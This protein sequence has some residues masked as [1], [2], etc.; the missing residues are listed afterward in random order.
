VLALLGRSIPIAVRMFLLTFAIVDDIAAILIIAVVY[1]GGLDY[2]GLLFVAA[3]FLVV[4]GFQAIGIGSAFA[5]LLPGAIL[6]FGLLDAG[7][8][9]TLA[10]VILGM[11]TPVRPMRWREVPLESAK[12]ALTD[13]GD[14]I[15]SGDSNKMLESVKTLET[16]QRDLLP[17]V[18]RVQAALHPWVAYGVMPLFA[19]ANAGVNLQ[20]LDLAGTS[21]PRLISAIGVALVIGKP[22]GILAGSWLAVRVGA[23]QLAPGLTWF[24]IL[25]AACLGGIGF[26]MSIFIASLAFPDEQMLAA[27]KLGVLVASLLA[28]IAG[29][30]V[31]RVYLR[32]SQATALPDRSGSLDPCDQTRT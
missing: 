15:R 14:R 6:W 28:G 20:G 31:G 11:M 16:A 13:L 10:G 3:G 19:L 8:H 27:A 1:S 5:Y 4:L 9:P 23:C 25:L 2:A 7:L 30:A 32:R 12:R 29:F 22:I 21:A 26:T 24:G 17:P 18:V